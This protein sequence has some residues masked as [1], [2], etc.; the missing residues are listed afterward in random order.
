LFYGPISGGLIKDK[1]ILPTPDIAIFQGG[2]IKK[3][4][5][6]SI[7]KSQITKPKYQTVRQAHHPEP[8]RRANHN[9][10]NPK[11]CLGH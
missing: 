7:F 8:S 1:N 3:I 4:P 6:T 2:V 9:D 10:Q 11:Q 5:S